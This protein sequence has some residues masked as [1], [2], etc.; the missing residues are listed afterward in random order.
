MSQ[1]DHIE[2]ATIRAIAIGVILAGFLIAP[3]HTGIA[4]AAGVVALWLALVGLLVTVTQAEA[5]EDQ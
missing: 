5:G 2:P 3:F 1:H 4:V